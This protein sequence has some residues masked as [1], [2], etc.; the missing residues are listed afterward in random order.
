[1]K[2]F[3]FY[4]LFIA[5]L[6]IS[7]Y[8][9]GEPGDDNPPDS[10]EPPVSADFNLAGKWIFERVAG[11]GVI[12][13]IPQDDIDEEP[14]G[15]VEFYDYGQG[16]SSL[17]VELLG[18]T[19]EKIDENINWDWISDD[20]IDIEE[21]DGAHEIWTLLEADGDII[22]AEWDISIAG[23]TATIYAELTRR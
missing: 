9:C 23:S 8:S 13:G 21:E 2:K 5:V 18:G 17:T 12:F 15:F 20:M 14:E 22:R 3:P 16:I 1:M 11:E 6:A 7:S 4:Y 19:I 10:N